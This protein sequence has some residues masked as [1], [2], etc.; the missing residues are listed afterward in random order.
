LPFLA[1]L[2]AGLWAASIALGQETN[3]PNVAAVA[4]TNN[5]QEFTSSPSNATALRVKA[6]AEG[7]AKALDAARLRG[8]WVRLAAEAKVRK[9]A[10]AAARAARLE[11]VRYRAWQK[12]GFGWMYQLGRGVQHDFTLAA[13]WCRRAAEQGDAGAQYKLVVY[14]RIILLIVLVMCVRATWKKRVACD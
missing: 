7:E 2:L 11:A 9:A 5:Q 8:E 4:N 12:A 13:Y 14:C 1:L 3:P 10:Q 6:K